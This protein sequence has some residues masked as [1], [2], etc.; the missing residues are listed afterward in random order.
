[1]TTLNTQLELNKVVVA[2]AFSMVYESSALLPSVTIQPVNNLGTGEQYVN[3]KKPVKF[4]GRV[5]S[6]VFSAETIKEQTVLLALI[7]DYGVDF[8]FDDAELSLSVE[9]LSVNYFQPAIKTIV[10]NIETDFYKTVVAGAGSTTVGTIA[11]AL[12]T[13]YTAGTALNERGAMGARKFIGTPKVIEGILKQG[14]PLFNDSTEL[15]KQYKEGTAGRIAGVDIYDSFRMPKMAV[16]T[17]ADATATITAVEGADALTVTFATGGT[18]S[19]GQPFTVAG[20]NELNEEG[21]DLGTLKVFRASADYTIVAATP[22]A[23]TVQHKLWWTASDSR[24]N[25]SATPVGS[26]A[27]DFQGTAGA[28]QAIEFVKE[29]IVLGCVQLQSPAGHDSVA[30]Y[31][32]DGLSIRFIRTFDEINA[33]WNCRFDCRVGYVVARPEFITG[34]ILT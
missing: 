34:L 6:K 13:L 17:I 4:N 18:L 22:I 33:V 15:A 27:V 24:K 8:A 2:N 11:T 29:A 1:M 20:V 9:D 3:L 25:L 10:K 21:V 5:G 30:T 14:R 26:K 31:S 12:D 32:E 19:M 16:G 23:I 28:N 7:K